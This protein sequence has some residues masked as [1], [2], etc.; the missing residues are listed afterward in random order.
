MTPDAEHGPTD[1]FANRLFL[2]LAVGT[3][4]FALAIAVKPAEDVSLQWL[5]PRAA[6]FG[7]FLLSSFASMLF[8][9]GAVVAWVLD[10]CWPDRDGLT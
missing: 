8:V 1:R 9:A 2:G 3:S 4:C 5:V 10:L 6:A 7:A